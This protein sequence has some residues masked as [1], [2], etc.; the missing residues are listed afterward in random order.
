MPK[1]LNT[2]TQS[3][4]FSASSTFTAFDVRDTYAY[5]ISAAVTVTTPAAGTFT[6]DASTDTCTKSSHGFT[7]GIKVQ[8]TTTGTL[9]AGLSLATDYYLIVLTASTFKVASS[10]ANA[11]AGTAID[12]TDSGSGTHT[13]TATALAGGSVNLQA[14]DGGPWVNI[15]GSSFAITATDNFMWNVGVVGYLQV[16]TLYTLTAGQLSVSQISVNKGQD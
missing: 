3:M 10:L 14:Y 16:R 9:P 7:T 8:F 12:I 5:N 4:E 2:V 15:D 6:A 1:H 13:V 11:Q